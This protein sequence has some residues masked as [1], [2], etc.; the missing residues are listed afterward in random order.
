[1]PWHCM[2]KLSGLVHLCSSPLPCGGSLAALVHCREN[3][4]LPELQGSRQEGKQ[5][6]SLFVCALPLALFSL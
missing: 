4:A 6:T 3:L 2:G 5:L 1:M